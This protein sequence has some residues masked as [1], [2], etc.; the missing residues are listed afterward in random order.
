MHGNGHEHEHAGQHAWH[1]HELRRCGAVATHLHADCFTEV[2]NMGMSMPSG[3]PM[4]QSS[5]MPMGQPMGQPMGMMGMYLACSI[6]QSHLGL[7][8]WERFPCF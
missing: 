4:G 6:L 2:P 7:S 1:G 8:L 3:M 5:C